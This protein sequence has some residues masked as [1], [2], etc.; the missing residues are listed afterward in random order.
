MPIFSVRHF[1]L[2]QFVAR[3]WEHLLSLAHWQY[4][5]GN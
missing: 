4:M 5:N 1:L 2:L 3:Q